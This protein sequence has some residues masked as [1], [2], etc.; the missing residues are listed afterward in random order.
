M[1][2]VLKKELENSDLIYV[3][4]IVTN[5]AKEIKHLNTNHKYILIKGS[6]EE[7]NRVVCENKH[8]DIFYGLEFFN[9]KDFIHSRNSG[10][11]QVLCK[12]AK[13]NDIV[14]G[15]SFGDLMRSQ[16]REIG[17]GRMMQNVLLC[18]KYKLKMFLGS[19]ATNKLE[20]KNKSEL[21]SFGRIIG[22]SGK[23]VKDSL[24]FK[25]KESNL[26]ILS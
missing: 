8:V 6:N 11:N 7:V 19:F 26:K 5:N 1:D 17:L 14:I 4:P 18:R 23:E 24:I 20:L 9:G 16:N 21:M 15:F 13:K 10:L 12:L 2:F 22:M 3:T 25:K